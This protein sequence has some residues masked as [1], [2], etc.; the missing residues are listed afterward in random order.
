MS[1][2]PSS[3]SGGW[4]ETFERLAGSVPGLG[5][6]QD[7][8]GLREADQR[9]RALVAQE[10]TG[11]GRVLEGV[12]QQLTDARLLESLPALDRVSRR[13]LTLADRVR[14]ARYGFTGVFDLHKLR[15]A[16]LTALHRFDLGLLEQIPRLREMAERLAGTARRRE[17][18]AEA[19]AAAE[20]GVARMDGLLEERDRLARGL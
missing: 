15:E 2:T 11:V 14:F 19:L 10:L 17:D 8:E 9:V 18:L 3:P 7:R 1:G 13:I 4:A 16:E 20:E 6:Y 12:V 5:Q